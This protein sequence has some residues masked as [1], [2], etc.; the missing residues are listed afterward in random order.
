MMES[1]EI[2]WNTLGEMT[3]AEVLE[4]AAVFRDAYDSTVSGDFNANDA[5]E[6][7]FLLNSAREIAENNAQEEAA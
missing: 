5:G 2:F 6:W 1:T 4:V 7:T 3:F